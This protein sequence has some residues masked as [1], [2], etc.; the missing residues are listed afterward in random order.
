DSTVAS[1]GY[2]A[3]KSYG[4][5]LSQYSPSLVRAMDRDNPTGWLIDSVFEDNWYGFYCYEADDVAIVGNIYRNNIVYGIDPHDRSHR[6]VMAESEAYGT[7][8]THGIIVSREVNESWIFRNRS[9]HNGL[10]GIV[11]DR[12]SVRN[13]VADNI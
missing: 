2:A 11:I 13:V 7:V 5:S 6:L 1:L 10:S 8:Q 9:H 4:V 3:S 12:S